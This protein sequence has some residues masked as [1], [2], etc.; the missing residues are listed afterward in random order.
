MTDHRWLDAAARLAARGAP[1]SRPNPAVGAIIVRAGQVVGRGWTQSGG[2]PHAEAVAL[3][4]AGPAAH[5][6]TLY[7]SLEP[8]AHTSPRGPACADLVAA[9]GLARVVI[10]CADP[11]P[12]TAGAGA[13]RIVAAGISVE[14]IDSPACAASLTGY[15][16]RTRLGRPLVTLKLALSEDGRLTLPPG[17][18]QWLTGEIARAHVHVMRAR[19][20]AIVVGRGTLEADAPRLDVRL[21]GIEDRSPARWLLTSGAA[22]AGWQA[23]ASPADIAALLPAQTLMV[24][25]GAATARAF[26][27]AGLVDRMLLYRAPLT[28]GGN[29]PALPELTT[30]ALAASPHWART[31][32]RQLGNDTLHVY[33]ARPCSPE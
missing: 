2:R 10:G 18:G 33:E 22:P 13:A 3:V 7:V 19:M 28:V 14:Q 1:L 27:S 12:R 11:D 26:L 5:G 4:Q 17:Q 20:D 8:C 6:G 16:T 24:E 9:S 25:G 23:L 21:P 15:L 32:Q 31:D 30:S 29:G